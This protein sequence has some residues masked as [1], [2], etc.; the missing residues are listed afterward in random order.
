[1]FMS[2]IMENDL[3]QGHNKD[4]TS[5]KADP[6]KAEY[7]SRVLCAQLQKIMVPI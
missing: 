1:M 4:C 2:A 3:Q 5:T 7:I 6:M